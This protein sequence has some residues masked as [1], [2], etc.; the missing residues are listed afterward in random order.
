MTGDETHERRDWVSERAA[1]TLEAKFEEIVKVM[2]SD[3][4]KVNMQPCEIRLHQLFHAEQQET[5]QFLVR[6]SPA[7]KP[8]DISGCVTLKLCKKEN[9]LMVC[10]PDNTFDI[11]PRW[12]KETLNCDLLID[13]AP[14]EAWRISQ[15]ALC[16]FFF[17]PD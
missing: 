2:R 17:E 14:F 4:E 7:D 9:K 8:S 16:D 1:C 10:C 12:N 6:R 13:D 15:K 5:G 11:Y 3:V